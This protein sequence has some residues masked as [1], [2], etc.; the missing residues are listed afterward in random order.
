MKADRRSPDWFLKT[1]G[2]VQG[3]LSEPEMREAIAESTDSTMLVRQGTSQWYPADVIRQKLDKLAAN[4]IFIRFKQVAEGPF[5]LD[6]AYELLQ[7]VGLEGIKVRTGPKGEW[8]SATKWL[9]A[10]NR[11]KRKKKEDAL[12][13][14][15]RLPQSAASTE[16]VA[17]TPPI[18]EAVAVVDEAEPVEAVVVEDE[19]PLA[20]PV[21]TDPLAPTLPMA[22]PVAKSRPRSR[23]NGKSATRPKSSA[24][25]FRAAPAAVTATYSTGDPLAGIPTHADLAARATVGGRP[26]NPR[27]SGNSNSTGMVAAAVLAVL[28]FGLI[29]V[30]FLYVAGRAA[31]DS[32]RAERDRMQREADAM[33]SQA[34]AS[35][36]DS[37]DPFTRPS[38]AEPPG[39]SFHTP[40]SAVSATAPPTVSAGSLFRP[41]FATTDGQVDAGTAFA[42]KTSESQK[43][44]LVTALHLF[45]PAGGLNQDINASLLP[46]RWKGISV[47]DCKSNIVHQNIAMQPV[48]LAQAKPLPEVSTHGDVAVCS[49]E[50]TGYLRLKPWTLATRIPS[51]GE[52]VWLVSAV[53]GSSSLIHP[54][55]VE[56][57]E[58]GWLVY[59]FDRPVELVATSGAPVIDG[60][61]QVV[62]VNAGGGEDAGITFGVGTPTTKFVRQLR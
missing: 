3:P 25:R 15:A 60:S 47:Q 43:T 48:R 8:V 33:R 34:S 37:W 36:P 5:T 54:A 4:G 11:L 53:I 38:T 31:S 44:F 40:V 59:R 58:D 18:V 19:I 14:V 56:G 9:R 62:A 12:A 23:F 50:N 27:T 49:V 41:T 29:G 39:P 55:T 17:A 22:E 52:K 24:N 46:T 35:S 32:F 2:R 10:V 61:G 1:N 57:T 20:Y 21:A 51:T 28:V 30:R 7:T 6:K 42:A 26:V 16:S 45:G 13:A